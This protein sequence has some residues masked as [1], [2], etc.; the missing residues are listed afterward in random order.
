MFVLSP[1]IM[2]PPGD[3]WPW[4]AVM[5]LVAIAPA[6]FIGPAWQRILGAAFFVAA[7]V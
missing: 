2:S 3:V 5:A 6:V 1:M 7:I 4:F